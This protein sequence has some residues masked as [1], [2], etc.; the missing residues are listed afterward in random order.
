MHNLSSSTQLVFLAFVRGRALDSSFSGRFQSTDSLP[1]PLYPQTLCVF[2]LKN[3]R[4]L[5]SCC[6]AEKC[7]QMFTTLYT[8]TICVRSCTSLQRRS[9][10]SADLRKQVAN[11][12]VAPLNQRSLF[13]YIWQGRHLKLVWDWSVLGSLKDYKCKMN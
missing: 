5:F 2:S 10:H 3:G 12:L 11:A 7:L 13:F 1:S 6:T 4:L 8:L 9:T